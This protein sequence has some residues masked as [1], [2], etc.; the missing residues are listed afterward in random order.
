MLPQKTSNPVN[1]TFLCSS[2]RQRHTVT[3]RPRQLHCSRV[4][5]LSQVS[6]ER[7]QRDTP[8]TS[9]CKTG[10]ALPP[11]ERR[12][13]ETLRGKRRQRRSLEQR[14]AT[15]QR[16]SSHPEQPRPIGAG[17]GS[18]RNRPAVSSSKPGLLTSSLK[19]NQT[20]QLNSR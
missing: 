4:T 2:F 17:N 7:N 19:I 18:R 1:G 6:R 5:A 11:L 20:A 13:H 3:S 10:V 9:A 12:V 15:K 8:R 16:C 14:L